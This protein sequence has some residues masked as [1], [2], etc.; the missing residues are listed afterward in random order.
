M[1]KKKQKAV[2]A[3]VQ[4]KKTFKP[5]EAQ[6]AAISAKFEPLVQRLKQNLDPVENPQTRNQC[7]DVFTKWWRSFYYIMQKFQ[8]PPEGY[9][10]PGFET[11][12]AR[13]EF[14]GADSFDLAFYRYTGEWVVIA[15]GQTLEECLKAVEEDS[16]FQV[17]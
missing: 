14:R 7:V 4:T 17:L 2:W 9:T 15:E 16:W 6:K 1:A 3:W 13:L 8:C 12:I 10:M 11:G 5:T